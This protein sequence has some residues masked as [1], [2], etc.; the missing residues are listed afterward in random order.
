MGPVG[1]RVDETLLSSL[2]HRRA[3]A[4][5]ETIGRIAQAHARPVEPHDAP[6]SAEHGISPEGWHPVWI[7]ATTDPP[8]C[9][10]HALNLDDPSNPHGGDW[11]TS[12]W[13]CPVSGVEPRAH[14]ARQADEEPTIGWDEVW[15]NGAKF[16]ARR[17]L[18]R[19][20]SVGRHPSADRDEPVWCTTHAR[21]IV[22]TALANVILFPDGSL[23]EIVPADQ[24]NRWV[25]SARTFIRMHLMASRIGRRLD[26]QRRRT[27]YCWQRT[28]H[29]CRRWD[30]THTWRL[31]LGYGANGR[32]A[33]R[34]GTPNNATLDALAEAYFEERQQ[35]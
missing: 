19:I 23:E 33:Q 9:G 5:Q 10:K 26:G 22:E 1:A 24:I 3:R 18:A 12:G 13:A 6:V 7:R 16:D 14:F 32:R 15:G 27:W 25:A 8:V 34:T 20:P 28:L 35:V 17:S 4:K 21:A 31:P 2:R 29:P 30:T 11:H